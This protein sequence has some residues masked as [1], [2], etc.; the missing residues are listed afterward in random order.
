MS[1]PGKDAGSASHSAAADPAG[2]EPTMNS[3]DGLARR[4][5]ARQAVPLNATHQGIAARLMRR[6][7]YLSA[8]PLL[9][10]LHRL[11]RVASAD[12]DNSRTSLPLARGVAVSAEHEF[13]WSAERMPG[14]SSAIVAGP[15]AVLTL[16]QTTH[17]D[18]Q[19]TAQRPSS[20]VEPAPSTGS[21]SLGTAIMRRH[22]SEPAERTV[23]HL[24]VANEQPYA[25]ASQVLPRQPEP[26][27]ARRGLNETSSIPVVVPVQPAE[28]PSPA[29]P[30]R[31]TPLATSAI[32]AIQRR[33]ALEAVPEAPALPGF[34]G[35][36]SLLVA[37]SVE[38][39][40]QTTGPRLS[41]HVERVSP[42]APAATSLARAAA[43]GRT[44]SVWPGSTVFV[45]PNQMR[46]SRSV[47][48]GGRSSQSLAVPLVL[49]HMPAGPELSIARQA[50]ASTP[51]GAAPPPGEPPAP[52]PVAPTA[53]PSTGAGQ[54]ADADELV[55]RVLHR[56]MRHLAVETERRGLARWP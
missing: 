28:A 31:S 5:I 41:V 29:L 38:Q 55:E 44:E 8:R 54:P 27:L 9:P 21:A 36:M 3:N 53:A 51:G 24:V 11:L 23:Q 45:S 37:A 26:V 25:R 35:E 17:P 16:V 48:S 56:L 7:S 34:A 14:G 1:Q 43:H 2:N 12:L 42:P 15:A 6:A 19:A 18:E 50:T 30:P 10:A 20:R 49:S 47:E 33:P 32:P 13:Q 46:L 40:T 39:P 4:L 22:L 52:S